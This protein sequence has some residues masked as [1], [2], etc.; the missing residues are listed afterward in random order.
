MPPA[1]SSAWISYFR[2]SISQ[3][4][5]L[6]N[7]QIGMYYIINSVQYATEP[8]NINFIHWHSWHQ[9]HCLHNS[10]C[11][12]KYRGVTG[13]CFLPT[14]SALNEVIASVWTHQGRGTVLKGYCGS[15]TQRAIV[16]TPWILVG[17]SLWQSPPLYTGREASCDDFTR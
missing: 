2:W 12:E 7:I 4:V 13:R 5:I 10:K 3:F 14:W 1:T 8:S 16:E 11:I 17:K 6:F 15:G 9:F